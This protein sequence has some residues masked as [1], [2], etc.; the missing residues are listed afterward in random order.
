MLQD[1]ATSQRSQRTSSRS[2]FDNCPVTTELLRCMHD[3]IVAYYTVAYRDRLGQKPLAILL[4]RNYPPTGSH[5]TSSF[6]R[7]PLLLVLPRWFYHRYG[8]HYF[9]FS[10]VSLLSPIRPFHFLILCLV[11]LSR[12]VLPPFLLTFRH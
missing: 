10:P 7:K 9:Y 12:I 4:D 6:H 11:S 8:L 1:R 3:K 5:C 2:E